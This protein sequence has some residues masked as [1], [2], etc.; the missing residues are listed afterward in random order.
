MTTEQPGRFYPAHHIGKVSAGGKG[1]KREKGRRQKCWL[2]GERNDSGGYLPRRRG[3]VLKKDATSAELHLLDTGHFADGKKDGTE[4]A[5][6]IRGVFMAKKKK[7]FQPPLIGERDGRKSRDRFA[8]DCMNSGGSDRWEARGYVYQR[9]VALSSQIVGGGRVYQIQVGGGAS[10][11]LDGLDR[12]VDSCG[13]Q[14]PHVCSPR[15]RHHQFAGPLTKR[16]KR[17]ARWPEWPKPQ[18]SGQSL[19]F[20]GSPRAPSV[21]KA[22]GRMAELFYCERGRSVFEFWPLLVGDGMPQ[23]A[24]WGFDKSGR[25]GVR[26]RTSLL[27]GTVEGALQGNVQWPGPSLSKSRMQSLF[28]PLNLPRPAWV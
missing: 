19:G 23:L 1:K 28:A 16:E 7:W 4:I 17:H 25:L 18:V 8:H 10:L 13:L 5:Q 27:G 26:N 12:K 20:P 21:R 14:R 22:V 15:G 3:S 24:I 2:S 6:L 11:G 9:T